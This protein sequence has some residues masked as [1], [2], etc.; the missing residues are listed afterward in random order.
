MVVSRVDP[1]AAKG[2]LRTVD[3]WFS[4]RSRW[5]NEVEEPITNQPCS[6]NSY[7]DMEFWLRLGL[8]NAYLSRVVSGPIGLAAIPAPTITSPLAGRLACPMM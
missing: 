5:R 1:S 4:R 3:G 8:P 7:S 6:I 2:L